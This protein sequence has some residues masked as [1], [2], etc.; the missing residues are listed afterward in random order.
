MLLKGQAERLTQL[1]TLYKDEQ[2][3]RKKY[4][5]QIEGEAADG[6][7]SSLSICRYALFVSRFLRCLSRFNGIDERRRWTSNSS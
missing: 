2:V 7:F 6:P 5:N 1:E 3:L 4:F